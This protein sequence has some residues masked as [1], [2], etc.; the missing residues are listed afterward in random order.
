MKRC[1]VA[2][3][4]QVAKRRALG[5]QTAHQKD[6]AE[7]KTRGGGKRSRAEAGVATTARLGWFKAVKEAAETWHWPSF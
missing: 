5:V 4:E 3:K 7:A 1:F 2:E 6:F